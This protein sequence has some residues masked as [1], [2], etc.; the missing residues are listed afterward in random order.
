M[1]IVVGSEMRARR[2]VQA[3]TGA[4]QRKR[5][6]LL[7]LLGWEGWYNLCFHVYMGS[8]GATKEE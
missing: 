6:G 3:S 1:W 8:L 4:A 7:Q 2:Y 5:F